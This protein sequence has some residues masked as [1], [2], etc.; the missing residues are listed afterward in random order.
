METMY[1]FG[2]MFNMTIKR[3]RQRAEFLRNLLELPPLKK[4]IG[5]MRLASVITSR[6]VTLCC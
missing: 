2:V 6:R 4:R 1:F 3:I 5:E